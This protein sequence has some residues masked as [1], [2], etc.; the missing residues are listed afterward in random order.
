[1]R[2]HLLNEEEQWNAT[3]GELRNCPKCSAESVFHNGRWQ[4][5]NPECTTEIY[6]KDY[7]NVQWFDR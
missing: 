2:L 4:C 7:R 3:E 5:L 1:M 6:H